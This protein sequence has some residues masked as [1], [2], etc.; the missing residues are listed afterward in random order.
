M[1][2]KKVDLKSMTLQE[3]NAYINNNWA[4]RK[5]IKKPATG[6]SSSHPWR[7]TRKEIPIK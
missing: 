1:K 4:N 5:K 2:K 3:K 7:E 6:F